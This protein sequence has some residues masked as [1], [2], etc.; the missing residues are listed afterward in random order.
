ML[1]TVVDGSSK[2]SGLRNDIPGIDGITSELGSLR[3][4]TTL[5]LLS[6]SNIEAHSDK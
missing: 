5:L 6:L 4:L 3:P 2:V 1:A